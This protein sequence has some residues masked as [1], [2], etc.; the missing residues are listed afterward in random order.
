MIDAAN[1]AE[2]IKDGVIAFATEQGID[3]TTTAGWDKAYN[4]CRAAKP[5]LFGKA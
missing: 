3:I 2:S 1:A 5:E 4:A